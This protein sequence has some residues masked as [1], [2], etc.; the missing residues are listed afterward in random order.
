MPPI[1]SLARLTLTLAAL[2]ALAAAAQ[3]P[4]AQAAA[5]SDKSAHYF[6]MKQVQIIDHS[7][8][9]QG[10]PAY[11]LMIPTTWEFTGAVKFGQAVG[12]CV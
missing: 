4:T 7:Q 8:G 3:G 12:R 5:A 1:A 9:P 2:A 10:I 11:D 6:L